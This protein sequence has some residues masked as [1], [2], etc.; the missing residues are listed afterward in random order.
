MSHK[1]PSHHPDPFHRPAHS[2]RVSL[3]ALVTV[4][5]VSGFLIAKF[6]W[7]NTT[8]ANLP[9]NAAETLR[10]C[11]LL[12]AEPGPPVDFYSRTQSDRFQPGTPPTLIRNATI[13]TGRVSGHETVIGDLLLDK[14]IIK[15][16]GDISQTTID[17]YGQQLVVVDAAGAWV[18]P[19]C[20]LKLLVQ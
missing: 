7:K 20:V 14:G 4:A 6:N 12:K 10:K 2:L 13:W 3:F 11:S 19:G 9:I 18:S 8:A 5:L 15:E 17:K 16:V 1:L